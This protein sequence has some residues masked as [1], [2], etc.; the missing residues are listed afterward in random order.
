V[1]RSRVVLLVLLPLSACGRASAA[2]E[3][4]DASFQ[5][6]A[7]LLAD[8]DAQVRAVGLQHV[9]TGAKGAA[10]TRRFAAMLTGLPPEVQVELLAALADRGDR[11]ARTQ[12]LAM[13]KNPREPV[14][15][16]ALAALGSL[17]E[18]ADVPALAA[19]LAAAGSAEKAAARQSLSRLRDPG[20]NQ[21]IVKQLAQLAPLAPGGR[22]TQ[23]V[24]GGE[25]AGGGNREVGPVRPLSPAIRAALLDILAA[26]NATDTID[27][28][29][30]AAEDADT[31][32]RMA[33]LGALR[34]LAEQ[35]RTAAVVKLLRAAR[36]DAER[37]R[38]EAALVAV[39][40]RGGPACVTALRDGMAGTAGPVRVALLRA[41]ARAGGDEAFRT[42][43][44]ATRDDDLPARDE[45]VRLLAGWPDR[46]AVPPLLALARQ[47]EPLRYRVLAITGLARLAG[48]LPNHPPELPVLAETLKLA[49]RPEEKRTVLGVLG[50]IATGEALALVLP[51]IDD[52]EV[53]DEAS[54]AALGIVE[55]LPKLDAARRRA[56]SEKV[57]ARSQSPA[58]RARAEALAK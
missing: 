25:G 58:L 42:I 21:A 32:V 11:A 5:L 53:C 34:I 19:A 27:T 6:V 13:L 49:R 9:R 22:G 12:V 45:A 50:G 54:A 10:A 43:L 20:T 40:G 23:R 16:A 18:A 4:A 8:Q 44:A 47:A 24:P 14:R 17:G 1:L 51:V 28:V 38:A 35:G 26:R 41:L 52:A 55:Q 2:D 39:C 46:S 3:P 37:G 57:L 48:P 15:A 31:A 56:V 30:A 7:G 29:L 33:A 36:S